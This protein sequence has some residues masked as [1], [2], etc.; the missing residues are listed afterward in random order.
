MDILEVLP[1]EVGRRGDW[2]TGVWKDPSQDD[3]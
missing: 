1:S 3:R 2:V